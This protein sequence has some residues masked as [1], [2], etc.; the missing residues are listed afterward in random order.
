MSRWI[1][2]FFTKKE[3]PTLLDSFRERKCIERTF[4]VAR[5]DRFLATPRLNP[6]LSV[7]ENTA[8]LMIYVT[9][10]RER[11]KREAREEAGGGGC[12]APAAAVAAAWSCRLF[13]GEPR[14]KS[15]VV[16]A[17]IARF[18]HKN[19]PE[20]FA[21]LRDPRLPRA[22]QRRNKKRITLL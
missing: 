1:I 2:F 22:R 9:R 5:S 6:H 16:S 20:S 7:R 14:A 11:N 19:A 21:A 15:P 4:L 13:W 10:E 3:K 12:A 8:R 18:S 17:R